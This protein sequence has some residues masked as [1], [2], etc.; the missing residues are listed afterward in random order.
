MVFH[1]DYRLIGGGAQ[2]SPKIPEDEP[3]VISL[4]SMCIQIICEHISVHRTKLEIL[5]Q[6]L[7]NKILVYSMSTHSI[8]NDNVICSCLTSRLYEI[9]VSVRDDMC[10]SLS[11]IPSR[12][13]LLTQSAASHGWRLQTVGS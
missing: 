8:L 11:N 1:P 13:A 3:T 5:P 7:I 6:D 4:L 9:N 2:R 10:A 12:L